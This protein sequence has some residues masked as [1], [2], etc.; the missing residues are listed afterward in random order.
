[1]EFTGVPQPA[2][3]RQ[4]LAFIEY[5]HEKALAVFSPTVVPHNELEDSQASIHIAR[6]AALHAL[7]K[8]GWSWPSILDEEFPPP[9]EGGL[10]YET[11]VI[12]YV[13]HID[14]P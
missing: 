2:A 5:K 4:T 9:S 6:S 12:E 10:V 1:M 7:Q 11:V 8:N 13:L 3:P 14:Q